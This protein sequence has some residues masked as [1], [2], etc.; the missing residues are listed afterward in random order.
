MKRHVTILALLLALMTSSQAFGWQL[1]RGL[2]RRP[3]ILSRRGP[4]SGSH[5]RAGGL[6]ER[7]NQH[8]SRQSR[9]PQFKSQRRHRLADVDRRGDG[10]RLAGM[11]WTRDGCQ[12]GRENA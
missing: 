6:L 9:W 1:T 10:S 11:D 2:P 5:S 8:F 4:A 7:W 3:H 12:T